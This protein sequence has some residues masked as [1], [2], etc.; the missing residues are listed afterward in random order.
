MAEEGYVKSF[1]TKQK[2]TKY[3]NLIRIIFYHSTWLL[4]WEPSQGDWFF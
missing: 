4:A 2:L 3:M 1:T